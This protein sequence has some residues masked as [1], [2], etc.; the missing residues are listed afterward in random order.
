MALSRCNYLVWVFHKLKT[1]L[2]LLL[3]QQQ[4]HNSTDLHKATNK[5]NNIFIVVPYSKGLSEHFRNICRKVGGQ[6]HFKGANTVK[7]LLVA[8]KDKDSICKQWGVI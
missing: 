2:N 8:A 7:E 4:W 3:S 1:K 5:N 6:V